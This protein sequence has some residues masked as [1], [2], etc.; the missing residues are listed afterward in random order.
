M[1]QGDYVEVTYGH[2]GGISSTTLTAEKQGR[3]VTQEWE[4]D[5]NINWLV[6]RELTRGGTVV[7][8]DRYSAATVIH[9]R[10]LIKETR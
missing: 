1:S 6:I 2:P 3:R 5:G 4:K 8:E 9:V 10:Q 7:R